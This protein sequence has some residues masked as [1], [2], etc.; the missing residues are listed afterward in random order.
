MFLGEIL[1]ALKVN[2]Y[3]LGSEELLFVI[4]NLLLR[5]IAFN[6]SM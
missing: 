3:V 1:C 5:D 4:F 2:C 6:M